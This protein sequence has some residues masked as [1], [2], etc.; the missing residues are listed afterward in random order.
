MIS[1]PKNKFV[2]PLLVLF[3]AAGAVIYF[4]PAILWQLDMRQWKELAAK[5]EKGS[6]YISDLNHWYSR[7]N[8]D[9]SSN[10]AASLANIGA[11]A[12]SLGD[13]QGAIRYYDKAL[14][15]DPKNR[16]ALNNTAVAYADLQNWSKAEEYYLRL[17]NAEPQN[18]AAYRMLGYLYRDRLGNPEDKIKNLIDEGLRSTNNSPDLLSWIISYYQEKNQAD[19][20]LPYSQI[21]A[22]Q[23]NQKK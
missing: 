21:L 12:G 17:I 1:L 23:L 6:E 13:V 14:L 10:D 16:I 9:D 3:V 18:T 11:L 8:D 20:A 4:L 19:K 15:R 22:D 7:L 5:K 2:Y